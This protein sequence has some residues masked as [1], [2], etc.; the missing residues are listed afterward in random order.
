MVPSAVVPE[1]SFKKNVPNMLL[2]ESFRSHF[3]A[4]VEALL[5]K[6]SVPTSSTGQ[7]HPLDVAVN[8]PRL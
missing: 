2:L 5:Q 1:A 6:E 4:K 7:L 3:T 8:A